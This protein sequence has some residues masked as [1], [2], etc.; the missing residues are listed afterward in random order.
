M[1]ETD[2]QVAIRSLGRTCRFYTGFHETRTSRFCDDAATSLVLLPTSPRQSALGLRCDAHQG[3][4]D[5]E[6]KGDVIRAIPRSLA[7]VL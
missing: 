5:E 6:K 4:V 1:P 3:M 2:D 7:K